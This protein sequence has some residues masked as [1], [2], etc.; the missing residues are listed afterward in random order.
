MNLREGIKMI[1]VILMVVFLITALV[2]CKLALLMADKGDDILGKLFL[3]LAGIFSCLF[4]GFLVN[5]HLA[6]QAQCE[7][8]VDF[9][10]QREFIVVNLEN[11]LNEYT[12]SQA[13]EF[14]E[15]LNA[16]N[17]YFLRFNIEYRDDLYI[18]IDSYLTKA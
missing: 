14:N 13:K 12:I 15:L 5:I 1:F 16:H 11:N 6:I 8:R 10:N 7:N 3:S 18:D 4:I 2:F 17:N 9:A